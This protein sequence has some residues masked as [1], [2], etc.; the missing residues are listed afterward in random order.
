VPNSTKHLDGTY[1]PKQ[2]GQLNFNNFSRRKNIVEAQGKSLNANRFENI[3]KSPSIFSKSDH[4]P[5][6]SFEKVSGRKKEK[7]RDYNPDTYENFGKSIDSTLP[8]LNLGIT[9]F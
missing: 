6:F 5:N 3:N 8:K 4:I 1:K 7:E 2:G 9:M